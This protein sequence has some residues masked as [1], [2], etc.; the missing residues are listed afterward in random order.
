MWWDRTKYVTLQKGERHWK[1]S[2]HF[3]VL[4]SVTSVSRAN[5]PLWDSGYVLHTSPGFEALLS[6]ACVLSSVLHVA[7]SKLSICCLNTWSR[8]CW[9]KLPWVWHAEWIALFRTKILLSGPGR[10]W[11][12]TK[13][14]VKAIYV[15]IQEKAVMEPQISTLGPL[16]LGKS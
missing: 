1:H 6:L 5:A 9:R 7:D 16:Y 10:G 14:L 8:Q 12:E 3:G 13:V 2:G 15:G 11:E 4:D